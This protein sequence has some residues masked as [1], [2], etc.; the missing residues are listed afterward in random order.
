MPLTQADTQ[1]CHKTGNFTTNF[2]N[3][4][5][6][7]LTLLIFLY[8]KKKIRPAMIILDN[9]HKYSSMAYSFSLRRFNT[10]KTSGFVLAN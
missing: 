3:S 6:V 4:F 9:Y 10:F 7:H 8:V 2:P 5:E 1:T